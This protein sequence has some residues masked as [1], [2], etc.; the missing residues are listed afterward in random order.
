MK[1]F[2]AIWH[3]CIIWNQINGVNTLISPASHRQP[4]K[5]KQEAR[6]NT[7][8]GEGV[9]HGEIRDATSIGKSL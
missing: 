8:S 3:I 6:M 2:Y 9:E 1:P 7:Q 4:A 5:R